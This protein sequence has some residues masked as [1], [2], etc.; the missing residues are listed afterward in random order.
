MIFDFIAGFIKFLKNCLKFIQNAFLFMINC[1]GSIYNFI[2]KL[3]TPKKKRQ[4]QYFFKKRK[5]INYA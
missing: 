5:Y 3:F 2:Y 4:N 1:F